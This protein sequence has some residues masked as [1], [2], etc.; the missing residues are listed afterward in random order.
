MIHTPDPYAAQIDKQKKVM[1]WAILGAVVLLALG[2]GIGVLAA[3]KGPDTAILAKPSK[4]SPPVLAAKADAPPPVL[5]TD[6]K[7]PKEVLDWLMHLQKIDGDSS[8]AAR[9]L[10][11]PLLKMAFVNPTTMG[12]TQEQLFGEDGPDVEHPPTAPVA[13]E[14]EKNS[15]S[16][17]RIRDDYH[18]FPPPPECASIAAEYE[19]VISEKQQ[20]TTEIMA[21]INNASKDPQAAIDTLTH[22]YGT[23]SKRID[24]AA[25]RADKLVQAICDKY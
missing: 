20:M 14:A 15:A 19:Q 6:N 10:V 5:N 2:I 1:V 18:S 25:K 9:D 17:V 22:T 24:D 16:W 21:Q 13:K 3:Q 23:S 12:L 7:M 4:P 8:S 11:G